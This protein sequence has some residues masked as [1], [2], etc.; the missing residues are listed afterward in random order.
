MIQIFSILTRRMLCRSDFMSRDDS[1][2]KI[3]KLIETY[4]AMATPGAHG[5]MPA[6]ANRT[7]P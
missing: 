6:G 7:D 1:A 2:N 4:N 3:T 5:A